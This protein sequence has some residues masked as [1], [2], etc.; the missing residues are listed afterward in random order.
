VQLS[1]ARSYAWTTGEDG[2]VSGKALAGEYRV[3]TDAH[4]GRVWF[5]QLPAEGVV[6]GP[7]S[8]SASLEVDVSAPLEA[9]WI[10]RGLAQAP[11]SGERP[12]PRTEGQ[13]VFGVDSSVRFDGLAPGTWTVVGMRQAA[14]LVRT[15]QVSGSTRLSL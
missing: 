1:G 10:E 9:L 14:P 2:S 5:V 4:P 11:T 3:S 15:V 13:L 12:G 6:L 7:A 8:G